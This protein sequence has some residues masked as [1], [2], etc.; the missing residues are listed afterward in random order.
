VLRPLRGAFLRPSRAGSGAAY[1]RASRGAAAL[2]LILLCA[3][4]GAQAPSYPFSL[5][6]RVVAVTDGDT[7]KVLKDN[8]Q[9]K[10]RLNGIDAPE[11]KQAFG[12]KSKEYL[13]SL[14]AGKQVEVIVRDTDR[15]GRFVGDVF[16][17][18]KSACAELVAAGFAWHYVEYS[19]DEELAALEKWAKAKKLGLW[20]DPH[21]VP[22]WDYRRLKRTKAK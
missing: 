6:G 13:A 12:R 16:V 17:A 7:I 1:M 20:S 2:F 21:P 18:G 15:Y 4:V 10:I 22:P 3:V 8:K 5:E 9:H 19:E 11:M 14:V